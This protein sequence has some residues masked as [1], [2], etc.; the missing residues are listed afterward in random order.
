VTERESSFVIKFI[1]QA[2]VTK[3]ES[4]HGIEW[5]VGYVRSW[6]TKDSYDTTSRSNGY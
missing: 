4:S 5:G 1:A 2:Y 3:R 6:T